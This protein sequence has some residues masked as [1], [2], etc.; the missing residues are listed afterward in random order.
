MS[1]LGAKVTA[2]DI[3]QKNINV[4]SFHSNKN[5]LKINYFVLISE[6]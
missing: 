6:K 2:I 3:T 5:K 4:A 1:R